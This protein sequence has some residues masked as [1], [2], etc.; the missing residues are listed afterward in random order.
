MKTEKQTETVTETATETVTYGNNDADRQAIREAVLKS[1]ND[2]DLYQAMSDTVKTGLGVGAADSASALTFRLWA[3]AKSAVVD[4]GDSPS[5]SDLRAAL[6]VALDPDAYVYNK[7][8]DPGPFPGKKGKDTNGYE[9]LVR[10]CDAAQKHLASLKAAR[11]LGIP[12]P[13]AEERFETV[14]EIMTG[15]ARRYAASRQQEKE[16]TQLRA[17]KALRDSGL[18]DLI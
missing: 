13:D 6:L 5:L 12:Y 9:W 7:D 4:W 18:A 2:K 15:K 11:D 1:L 8:E 3:I 14:N 16:L 10:D 17:E